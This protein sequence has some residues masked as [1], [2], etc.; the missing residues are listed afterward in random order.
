LIYH[1]ETALDRWLL[2]ETRYFS[3]WL[4]KFVMTEREGYYHVHPFWLL[5]FIIW[6]GYVEWLVPID[7]GTPRRRN[8]RPGMILYQGRSIGHRVL[9]RG[10]KPSW[11]FCIYGPYQGQGIFFKGGKRLP[12]NDYMMKTRTKE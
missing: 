9:L 4:H 3:V 12:Y 7:G 6:R 11:S 10:E 2:W 5:K 1:G 8:C